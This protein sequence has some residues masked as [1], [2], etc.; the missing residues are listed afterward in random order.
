MKTTSF[1]GWM[2]IKVVHFLSHN[3][4]FCKVPFLSTPIMNNKTYQIENLKLIMG[5]NSFCTTQDKK[6]LIF[7]GVFFCPIFWSPSILMS[8]NV[9]NFL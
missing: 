2:H 4:H 1:E 5:S 3:A 6:D 7:N 9:S 8:Q